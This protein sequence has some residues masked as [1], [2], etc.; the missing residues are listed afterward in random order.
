MELSFSTIVELHQKIIEKKLSVPELLQE[1]LKV[2]QKRESCLHSYISIS[3]TMIKDAEDIQKKIDQGALTSPLAGIPYGLKDNICTSKMRTTCASR[4]LE[5]YHSPYTATAAAR[6]NEAGA[7]L[8]GKC[9]MDEFAMGNT[10]QTSYF[11]KTCNPWDFQRIPGGSSGGSAAAVAAG[12]AIFTLGNDTGGS[13]RQPAAFCGITGFKPTYGTVS[14]YGLV[15]FASSFDQIGPM[16]RTAEDCAI[17]LNAIAGPDKK[18]GILFPKKNTYSIASD[19]DIKE[20]TIG[21]LK[22]Q[23]LQDV[24]KPIMQI[25]KD[26]LVQYEK[27]GAEILECALPLMK[28]FV[29]VYYILSSAEAS[30]NLARFDGIRY[31]FQL[32]NI[33][34]AEELI[35][36]TRSRGFGLEVKRRILI[37]TFVLSKEH[38]AAYYKKALLIKQKIAESFAKI[39][40]QI[41]LL[42]LPVSLNLVPKISEIATEPVITYQEDILTTAANLAGLPA[43]SFPC[44]TDENGMPIGLQF[45]AAPGKDNLL[46]NAVHQFQKQTA[47][48]LITPG[49]K[50]I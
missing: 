34:N 50:S 48:H 9:N 41:D 29:P 6:L 21:Y 25:Y 31:G 5:A 4:M 47:Y 33:Q 39:F 49:G 27:M 13:I 15:A 20:Y 37:G 10:S 36:G 45:M 7:L 40:E 18:D 32:E 26:T 44:G 42:L 11:E 12:E 43:I 46:L 19:F 35:T 24:Q 17:I 8:I 2:I 28:F 3:D 30:S 1:T 14:R 38:Y 16:A 23:C 22:D